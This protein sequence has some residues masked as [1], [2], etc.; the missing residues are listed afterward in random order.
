[1]RKT[2]R[3]LLLGMFIAMIVSLTAFAYVEIDASSNDY[4]AFLDEQK[5]AFLITKYYIKSGVKYKDMHTIDGSVSKTV[6]ASELANGNRGDVIVTATVN[7]T[8]YYEKATYVK[9]DHIVS[10]DGDSLLL[11]MAGR[12]QYNCPDLEGVPECNIDTSYV[13]KGRL[14][15]WWIHDGKL[16]AASPDITAPSYRFA[17][18]EYVE[19]SGIGYAASI[20]FNGQR[21]TIILD[22]SAAA[23]IDGVYYTSSQLYDMYKPTVNSQGAKVYNYGLICDRFYAA[24]GF[25]L[26]M[27]E[28][29]DADEYVVV[30]SGSTIKYS[31][32]T[33][34]FKAGGKAIALDENSVIYY[35]YDSNTADVSKSIGMYCRDSIPGDA[36]FTA[37]AKS[38]MY[39]IYDELVNVYYLLATIISDEIDGGVNSEPQTPRE[40][41][42]ITNGSLV[43]YSYKTGDI[44]TADQKFYNSYYF[45]KLSD[46]TNQKSQTNKDRE[47]DGIYNNGAE[48]GYFYGWNSNTLTYDKITKNIADKADSMYL[49]RIADITLNGSKTVAV[50]DDGS[51]CNVGADT[52]IWGLSDGNS[53]STY[54]RLTLSQL[55]NMVDMV[56]SYNAS[57][58]STFAVD[59]LVIYSPKPT[60][61]S[62]VVEIF[63]EA[64]DNSVYSVNDTIFK[65]LGIPSDSQPIVAPVLSKAGSAF[66]D[67]EAVTFLWNSIPSAT[68]YIFEVKD[69]LGNKV[70]DTELSKDVT[71]YSLLL[72]A[73]EYKV[74]VAGV[75]DTV[76]Y[77]NVVELVVERKY[78]TV[79]Y[80]VNGGNNTP[81]PQTKTYG[82]ELKLT[83]TLPYL[84]GKFFVGWALTP[85]SE[86]SDYPSGGSFNVNADTVLYAVWADAPVYV[87]TSLVLNAQ[88]GLRMYFDVHPDLAP[89]C[90]VHLYGYNTEK[91]YNT[92]YSPNR[93]LFYDSGKELYYTEVKFAPRDADNLRLSASLVCGDT[94]ELNTV[95]VMDYIN[96]F[97][98]LVKTDPEMIKALPLVEAIETYCR[99]ADAY[100]NSKDAEAL[101]VEV[102]A[103]TVPFKSGSADGITH[104][105]TSLVLES[106]LAIRHYF[107]VRSDNASH[108]FRVGNN[109]LYPTK[110]GS[111]VIYVDV[112]VYSFTQLDTQY[113]LT[114]DGSLNIG[115]S[116]NNYLETMSE[117]SEIGDLVKALYNCWYCANE[118][119]K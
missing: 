40:D 108:S 44:V 19:K 107:L 48:E 58:G 113:V 22:T 27:E 39:M 30:S 36:D 109:L 92:I 56:D 102:K 18:L 64:E 13:G 106:Q 101:T 71:E 20:Y 77:S 72:D 88:L 35:P 14:R 51:T 86:T 83:N 37:T 103:S 78:F 62:L 94:T 5:T 9:N 21:D 47:Y 24:N 104:L 15:D 70:H 67:T 100:F 76:E 112:P 34:I 74:T 16:V 68:G 111:G 28:N 26:V 117:D 38:D 66:F 53:N 52:V 41:D 3:V 11:A 12:V 60:V 110:P 73:G 65:N 105:Q 80:N 42:Y 96:E 8:Q 17:V 2:V 99:Y 89:K 57:S 118:Y 69:T 87:G 75:G 23:R 49:G 97:K 84:Q 93:T 10:V 6:L 29:I 46:L 63:E 1:M 115:Y 43:L 82:V 95:T 4:S 31:A 119:Y 54:K 61:C 33:G 116:I 79:S 114:V 50:F 98:R 55:I 90:K 81:A 32:I 91:G 85:T 45:M 25:T 7:G 59:A